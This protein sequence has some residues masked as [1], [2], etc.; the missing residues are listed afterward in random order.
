MF[1]VGLKVEGAK[2]E[3]EDAYI[4]Y[5]KNIYCCYEESDGD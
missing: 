5:M 1:I 4:A 3:K 2:K